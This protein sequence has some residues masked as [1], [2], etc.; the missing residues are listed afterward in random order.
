MY[1]D[2]TGQSLPL[3]T[4]KIRENCQF[5][6]KTTTDLFSGKRVVI[7]ALPGAFTL[8]CSLIHLPEYDD[9][10]ELFKAE[11]IDD[12]CCVAVNDGF[13]M[14][15][16][17]RQSKV[18][19]VKMVPDVKGEFTKGLEMTVDKEEISE[20]SWR[21][22]MIV[23]DG[24]IEKM[25]IEPD[26]Q[27]ITVSRAKSVLNQIN[28]NVAIPENIVLFTLEGCPHCHKAKQMLIRRELFFTEKIFNKDYTLRELKAIAGQT[29][30]PQVFFDGKNIG[31]E[32]ELGV[33][34]NIPD[35]E[36]QYEGE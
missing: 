14:E 3:V 29:K 5:V 6:D 18:N 2:L 12:I 28:P 27:S 16:W 13:V 17:A 1:E 9:F 20:R 30:V 35:Q 32:K 22:A 26:L 24:V 19:K 21:Y 25:F 10:F 36:E 7:F 33:F 8:V 23:D 31:G 11:G 4:F 34:L 15:E